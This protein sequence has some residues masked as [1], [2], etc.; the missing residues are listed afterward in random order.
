MRHRA[1][2]FFRCTEL[3]HYADLYR[4]RLFSFTFGARI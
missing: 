1:S 2:L 4:I 3:G